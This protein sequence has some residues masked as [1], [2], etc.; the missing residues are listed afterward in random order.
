[1]TQKVAARFLKMFKQAFGPNIILVIGDWSRQG[2]RQHPPMPDLKLKRLLC[3]SGYNIYLIDG[4]HTSK[5]CSCCDG[6]VIDNR[7]TWHR[8]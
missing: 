8:C 1:M 6:A 4:Y 7:G 5:L 3:Q 2:A